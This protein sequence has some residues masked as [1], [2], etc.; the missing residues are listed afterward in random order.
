SRPNAVYYLVGVTKSKKSV[1]MNSYN[2]HNF[3]DRISEESLTEIIATLD[4]EVNQCQLKTMNAL[5]KDENIQITKYINKLQTLKSV[6][7]VV[8]QLN[9][10]AFNDYEQKFIKDLVQKI[11]ERGEYSSRQK[12]ELKI[13]GLIK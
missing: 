5:P 2:F 1:S 12:N 3:L 13:N 7:T 10:N 9:P 6:I 4:T 11:N 8:I